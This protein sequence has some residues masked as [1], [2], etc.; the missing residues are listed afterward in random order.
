MNKEDLIWLGAVLDCE[1]HI[2]FSRGGNHST[3]SIRPHVGIS[4]QDSDLIE[5]VQAITKIGSIHAFGP[6]MYWRLNG[7]RRVKSFLEE[8]KPFITVKKAQADLMVEF[9][10]QNQNNKAGF[11]GYSNRSLEIVKQVF[12]LNSGRI[13]KWV[14]E[15]I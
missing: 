13:P 14:E 2:C 15:W 11:G 1:G 3:T 5:R 9:C 12:M 8:V 10:E 6:N 4:N 7:M